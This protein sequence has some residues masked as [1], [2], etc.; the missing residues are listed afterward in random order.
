V[1]GKLESVWKKDIMVLFGYYSDIW[2]ERLRFR[3]RIWNRQL[4]VLRKDVIFVYFLSLFKQTLG[5]NMELGEERFLLRLFPT[6]YASIIQPFPVITQIT[7]RF[8]KRTVN[9]YDAAY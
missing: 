6:L 1:K 7:H 3:D 5:Y 8:F 9:N 4:A 2:L